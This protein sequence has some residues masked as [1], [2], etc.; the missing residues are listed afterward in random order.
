[1]KYLLLLFYIFLNSFV[2]AQKTDDK[3]QPIA[4]NK[5]IGMQKAALG[6]P[7]PAFEAVISGQTFSEKDL[8]GKIVFVNF[9]FA[10]CPPCIGEFE[11]LNRLYEKY[12]SGENFEFVSFTFEPEE[13]IQSIKKKYNI[14]YDIISI[15]RV[16]CYRL[17]QNPGFPTNIILDKSSV[18]KFLKCGGN[19]DPEKQKKTVE[20]EFYP[21]LE[22][23]L[24]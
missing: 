17:N 1:M 5:Y 12:K 18:I 16:D 4:L 2:Q 21:A 11:A 3:K 8:K 15:P 7:F 6:K 14:K 24:K 20:D 22:K 19:T 23:E 10:A 9:W 13:T